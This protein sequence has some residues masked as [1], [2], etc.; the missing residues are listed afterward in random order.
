MDINEARRIIERSK[1][2]LGSKI[3]SD[4]DF[5][6]A[7]G[8]IEGYERRDGEVDELKKKLKKISAYCGRPLGTVTLSLQKYAIDGIH[9]KKT[10]A[11]KLLRDI[12]EV[13]D[14]RK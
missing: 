6:I 10:Q 1:T 7:N 9:Y 3:I 5:Y 4:D 2:P 12:L 8:F 13:A 14:E 11:D